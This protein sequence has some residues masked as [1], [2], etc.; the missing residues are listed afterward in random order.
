M[1]KSAVPLSAK[2]NP[3][4]G[5]IVN[6]TIK[7]PQIGCLEGQLMQ[8]GPSLRRSIKEAAATADCVCV[9]NIWKRLR[10]YAFP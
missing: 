10:L 9:Q 7:I 4:K 6:F 8:I 3:K 1:K 5:S 2:M